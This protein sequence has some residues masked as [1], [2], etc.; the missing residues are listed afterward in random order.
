MSVLEGIIAR[1]NIDLKERMAVLPLESFAD[2]LPSSRRS[3][4]EALAIRGASF[5][6]E[7][8]KA[9]PSEGP[10]RP[11]FDIDE[12]VRAYSP[13]ADA[14]SVLTDG[15]YFQGS[16]DYLTRVAET[17]GRPV[18]CKDFI[19]SPYQVYEAR[20]HGA[21]AVLL[22]LSVLEDTTY[23]ACADA[24][25]KLSMDILTEVHDEREL[26]RA[27]ALGAE[28]VG[29]NNRDL[30]TLKVDLGLT[31]RLATMVPP[32]RTIV[33]E[34]GIRTRADIDDLA[35]LVD[36]FLIGGSLMKEVRLDLAVRRL[37]FGGVKICG[38]A[39]AE[40]VSVAY[41]AGAS[42]GGLIFA[43]GSPRRI[44]E[45]TAREVAAGA[46]LPLVGVFVN[47][48]V[49]AVVRLVS[50]LELAAVQ[51]HGDETPQYLDELRLALPESCE[52]WKA[53]PV[54]GKLPDLPPG[55]DRVLLDTHDASVRGGTGKVFDWGLLQDCRERSAVI[56]AG[57]ITPENV[58]A[59]VR[60]GCHAIDVNSGVEH[61]R[62]KK[63]RAKI[64]HLFDAIRGRV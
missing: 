62:G 32:G 15:P 23:V 63:D 43:E 21:D 56:L 36:A 13:F 12:I 39:S 28:I 51:L 38:L 11:D 24:A 64:A 45:S 18:L 40:D 59:A 61:E 6:L 37:L 35:G 22:M 31:K 14:I 54:R 58:Q 44:A 1:K 49:E 34:S 5:I 9:S 10:I 19:V 55:A 25:R 33:C 7:C 29:I 27:V 4:A 50:E 3:F 16:F 2:S 47:D 20:L 57:G 26:E 17:S 8:K 41:E 60:C 42:Y 30:K 52:I 48:E 53:V 46:K